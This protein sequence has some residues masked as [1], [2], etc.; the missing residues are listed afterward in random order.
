MAS[1]TK[2]RKSVIKRKRTAMGKTR[3]K[4]T[5]AG[6]TPR[7]PVHVERDPTAVFPQPPGTHPDEN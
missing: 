7:F 5:E 2:H 4:A 3:K 6:T 1:H